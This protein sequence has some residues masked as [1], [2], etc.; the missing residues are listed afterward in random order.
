MSRTQLFDLTASTKLRSCPVL[1]ALGSGPEEFVGKRTRKAT[2]AATLGFDANIELNVEIPSG[3]HL[4]EVVATSS[5]V[6]L[7]GTM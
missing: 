7:L 1:D 2:G 5:L 6:S 3:Q 4:S